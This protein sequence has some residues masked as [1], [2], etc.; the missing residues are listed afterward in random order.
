VRRLLLLIYALVL[1]DEITLLAIVPLVPSYSDD[2]GLSSFGSGVLLS[3]SSLAIV[4]GS[5]P[6]G[7]LADRLGSR[8]V[9]LAG[10]WLLVIS[11]LGQA[12]A[13]DFWTLLAARSVFGVASAVI[14]SAGLSWLSDSAGIERPGALGVVISVAGIGG[15]AGPAFAGVLADR[16]SRAAPFFILAIAATLV[17][18]LLI[19]ADRGHERSHA[20]HQLRE[21]ARL[22]RRDG[23][24]EGA[25]VAMLIG[26]FADGLV[27][28]VAPAQLDRSGHSSAWI[29]VALSTAALLFIVSSALAARR[30]AAVVTLAVI[31]GCAGLTGLVTVP[32]LV[33]GTSAVVVA[34]LLLRASPLAVMYTVAFPIGV[35]GASR[36][37]MGAG[38]VN[39]LLAFAWGGSNFVGSLSAGGL[40]QA[41]G[42][43]G[44]YA[45]LVACCGLAATRVLVLRAR[46]SRP[47]RSPAG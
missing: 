33:S 6:G 7:V 4:A 36:S 2:F 31:A 1:L 30:A 45:V 34:M 47:T 19:T 11:C 39:G 17:V 41:V 13:P 15:M 29:G 24:I 43:R 26:G 37:G 20:H 5:I 35:R 21:I 23:L 25:L 32:V 16:V 28:L 14:W 22:A 46:E 44:V 42:S 12:V 9:T 27:N 40:N 38:A 10:G 3:A 8:R 18:A